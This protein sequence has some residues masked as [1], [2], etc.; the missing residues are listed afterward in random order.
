MLPIRRVNFLTGRFELV[1]KDELSSSGDTFRIGGYTIG[2]IRDIPLFRGI[3]T[4]VG[5]NLTAYTLPEPLKLA[6][7][8]RPIGGN[9]FLRIRLRDASN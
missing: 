4:G 3:E 6:Y 2:Y 9:I 8:D 7:G 1:D 5:A